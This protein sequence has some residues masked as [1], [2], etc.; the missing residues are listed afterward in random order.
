MLGF[1][2]QP[3]D[4]TLHDNWKVNALRGTGSQDISVTDLF[5]PHHHTFNPFAPSERGGAL[6]RI[7][8][9]GLFAMEHGAFA[10]RRAAGARRDGGLAK[11]KS[12]GYIVPQ[13]VAARGVFQYDLGR[14]ETALS[15]AHNQ[16]S[17]R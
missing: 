1:F 10:L 12:R 13:A 6:L 4:V 2:F 11:T 16:C 7:A 9:P 15:A 5:V 8:I 14:A 17:W 3:E